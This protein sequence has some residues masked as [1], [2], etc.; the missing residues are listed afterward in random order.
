MAVD[1][2]EK[3]EIPLSLFFIPTINYGKPATKQ[4]NLA[5]VEVE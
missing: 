5:Q 2:L 4:E 1:L 3:T